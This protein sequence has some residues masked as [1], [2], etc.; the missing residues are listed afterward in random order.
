[1]R[2][3]PGRLRALAAAV[4]RPRVDVTVTIDETFRGSP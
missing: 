4:T 1:M 3:A 2:I